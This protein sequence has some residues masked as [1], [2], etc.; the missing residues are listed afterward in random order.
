MPRSSS[1]RRMICSC[2]TFFSSASHTTTAASIAGRTVRMSW[3]N[4]T[5][6]GQSMKVKVSPMKF[7]VA[8]DTSTLILWS[9]A[10]LLASPTVVPASTV[11]GAGWRR[12]G[13]EL[14]REAWSCRFGK[15]PPVRCT[16]DPWDA[17]R[18][19]PCRPP[20]LDRGVGP[21]F[22]GPCSRQH[23][24]R[25]GRRWQAPV[26][27]EDETA[28]RQGGPHRNERRARRTVQRPGPQDSSEATS[29]RDVEAGL[30]RS[31]RQR[32]Q[33]E[34]AVG[35]ADQHVGAETDGDRSFRC[36]AGIDAGKERR[37]RSALVGE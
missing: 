33:G 2:G 12:C 25:R 10:S 36:R 26:V 19:V 13:R 15:G 22:P 28:D 6:P 9:R 11:P 7:V 3:M 17:C 21:M 5:E 29:G 35:A 4:S 30:C 31:D 32:L 37:G 20:L 24:L 27:A 1:S 23:R 18:F 34:R 16:V 8:T 14:L